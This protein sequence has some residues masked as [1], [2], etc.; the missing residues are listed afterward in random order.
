MK[1]QAT[2]S[3]LLSFRTRLIHSRQV[4]VIKLRAKFTDRH[5]EGVSPKQSRNI[6]YRIASLQA[7]RNDAQLFSYSVTQLFINLFPV[8]CPAT[9]MAIY[10]GMK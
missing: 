1:I 6:Q 5:C 9:A 4:N 2:G 3:C 7:A 10:K 8:I